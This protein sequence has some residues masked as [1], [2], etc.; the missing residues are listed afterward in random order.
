MTDQ[1]AIPAA[2][3]QPSTVQLRIVYDAL[4]RLGPLLSAHSWLRHPAHKKPDSILMPEENTLEAARQLLEWAAAVVGGLAHGE[5]PALP[6]EDALKQL[7][8]DL[9]RA[10]WS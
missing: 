9:E 1:T 2:D 6:N 4:M 3:L 7:R 10:R 5:R 8:L